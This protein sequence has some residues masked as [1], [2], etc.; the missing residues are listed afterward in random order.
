MLDLRRYAAPLFSLA[1][2]AAG[3]WVVCT[4]LVPWVLPFL[5]AL[6]FGALLEPLVACAT[7]RLGVPRW[8]SAGLATLL[9]LLV[10]VGGLFLL[11]WRM[12]VEVGAILQALPLFMEE[13]PAPDDLVMNWMGELVSVTPL[14]LQ[15]WLYDALQSLLSQGLTLPGQ[16]YEWLL[17][18]ATWGAR[19]LPSALLFLFTTAL[20]T[21]FTCASRPAL[22]AFLRR[23]VP[24]P[25]L[26]HVQAIHQR[27]T[28]TFGA[29]LHAQ[30]LLMLL[31]FAQL[32]VG[33]L[34]LGV[35]AALLL[36]FLVALVDALPVF[37]SGLFLLPAVAVAFF[38]G[39]TQV[40]LGL[41]A[42]Y[43]T[44][45]LVRNLVEPS[46]VGAGVGLPPLAA[47]LA[48]YVGM[49]TFGVAGMVLAP[50]GAMLLKALHDGGFLRLWRE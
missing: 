14:P 28:G 33:F 30:G 19:A 40:A 15:S 8:C 43:L 27:L 48:M 11:I 9:L 21:Y 46:L 45:S 26:C 29:W 17:G 50:L 39:Y 23:Q 32:S 49:Q 4:F 42:L 16:V 35:D 3:L 2:A 24:R 5:L 38:S 7:Y 41:L 22:V 13:L 44:V 1:L 37:G 47:L 25:W 34:L 10:L 6:A 12:S 18:L 20:A 36:A 31:T